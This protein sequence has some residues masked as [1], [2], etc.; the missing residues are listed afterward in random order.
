MIISKTPYRI[1]F[2]GGGTDY[3][4][5]YNKNGGQVVSTT[6]DKYI[7][8]TLRY[9]PKFFEHKYR[10]VWSHI[11]KTKKINQIKHPSTKEIL[12]YFKVK[13]GVEIHYDGDLPS[14]S[15]IGSSSCFSVGLIN[16]IMELN[17]LPRTKKIVSNI[18][19]D[20]EQN[21]LKEAVGS[22]DQIASS[23]GGLNHIKFLKKN[24]YEIK[25]IDISKRK[26]KKFEQNLLLLFTGIQ[27]TAQ[28]VASSYVNNFKK[29]EKNLQATYGYVDTFNQIL[30]NGSIDDIGYLLDESW[31]TK[32][33]LSKIVSNEKID[34]YISK[35]K[36]NGALGCKIL[37]A[38]SGGF[39]LVYAEKNLHQK[40]IN[41]LKLINIPFNFEDNGSKI[42]F[43]SNKK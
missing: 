17:K 21:K 19:I 23:Y 8:I 15:G 35:A 5:W 16:A 32:K 34:Y 30:K 39:M 27:R 6:I 1:S 14:R 4:N 43:N 29:L 20:I 22:Q 33:R 31:E 12:K 13:E 28:E 26:K 2:F 18:A 7:Y 11:E 40:I 37:G 10:V 9:L 36:K 38:G 3:P 42:I 24:I 41:N 25:K